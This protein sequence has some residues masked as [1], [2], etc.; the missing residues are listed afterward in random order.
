VITTTI[1]ETVVS[2]YSIPSLILCASVTV[3]V[4]NQMKKLKTMKR[5]IELT[6]LI[7]LFLSPIALSL[8]QPPESKQPSKRPEIPDNMLN[9]NRTELIPVNY[10]Y[11]VRNN[12]TNR[13]R[14]KNLMLGI[15]STRD[16]DL[17]TTVDQDVTTQYLELDLEPG[18]SL[19]LKINIDVEP[20]AQASQA[21]DSIGVYLS[22]EPNSTEQMRSRIK[23]FIDE[24]TIQEHQGRDID[25]QALRWAYWNGTAWE[26]AESWLDEEGYL[27]TDTEH[28]S[29]WTIT[30]TE[31]QAQEP[32]QD[33]LF[34]PETEYEDFRP[35]RDGNRFTVETDKIVLNFAGIMGDVPKFTFHPADDNETMYRVFFHQLFEYNDTN[36]DD[37]FNETDDRKVN[38]FALPSGSISLEGPTNIRDED[39]NGT[40]IGASFNYTITD[41]EAGNRPLGDVKIRLL[42]KIYRV[43][44]TEANATARNELKIDVVIEEWEFEDS[45]NRLALWWSF[46]SSNASADADI[47]E[48][49]VTINEGYFSWVENATIYNDNEDGNMSVPVTSEVTQSE[50]TVNIELSYPSFEEKLVHD[51]TIGVASNAQVQEPEDTNWIPG[52]PAISVLIGIIVT[53]FLISRR[54]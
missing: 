25:P 29:T 18:E 34:D 54:Y 32:E 35:R 4:R 1:F 19:E 30:E 47:A 53:I 17:E 11:H 8:A 14:F 21:D 10:T 27:V 43:N 26:T 51:P 46:T 12:E 23:L 24:E 44:A 36:G 28:L 3:I 16:I 45:D 13:L 41:R 31:R 42:C 49:N 15:N 9:V 40:V 39:D 20:P 22:L 38:N 52:F 50:D 5:P 37:V 6:L 48:N 7:L 33:D 2:N